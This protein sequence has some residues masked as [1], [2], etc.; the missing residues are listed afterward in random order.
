MLPATFNQRLRKSLLAK[1][2]LDGEHWPRFLGQPLASSTRLPQ[3]RDLLEGGGFLSRCPLPDCHLWELLKGLH[4]LRYHDVKGPGGLAKMAAT[5]LPFTD[6]PLPERERRPQLPDYAIIEL[7]ASAH[8][9]VIDMTCEHSDKSMLSVSQKDMATVEG[10]LHPALFLQG[11]DALAV[12]KLRS[13]IEAVDR[14]DDLQEL[15]GI[16]AWQASAWLSKVDRA[17]VPHEL[18]C[19][20]E[21]TGD[22]SEL[23]GELH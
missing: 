5:D 15:L 1:T 23:H 11:R 3:G 6:L 4:T 7:T 2:P 21:G 19:L 14:L 12:P 22:I 9:N 13:V 10:A 17:L 20:E 8:N 18:V 16:Q